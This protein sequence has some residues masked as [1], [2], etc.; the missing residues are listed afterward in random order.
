MSNSPPRPPSHRPASL[1][2]LPARDH[3]G[4]RPLGSGPFLDTPSLSNLP[5]LDGYTSIAVSQPVSPLIGPADAVSRRLVRRRNADR[6]LRGAVGPNSS[7]SGTPPPRNNNDVPNPAP[8]P[9]LAPVPAP[10]PAA[11]P[12]VQWVGSPPAPNRI[13]PD[14]A[15]AADERALLRLKQSLTDRFLCYHISIDNLLY[16]DRDQRRPFWTRMPIPLHQG[17][18]PGHPHVPPGEELDM[19]FT[20]QQALDEDEDSRQRVTQSVRGLLHRLRR[21]HRNRSRPRNDDVRRSAAD[22]LTTKL[23]SK[24]Q[25]AGIQFKRRLGQGGFGAVFLFEMVGEKGV[26][27]PIVVKGSTRELRDG[28]EAFS[29]ELENINVSLLKST[30]LVSLILLYCILRD[31]TWANTYT[32]VPKTKTLY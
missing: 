3:S 10:A 13:A 1:A 20:Y 16:W 27:Y 24:F 8:I 30:D 11:A 21:I 17:E 31:V 29:G 4:W 14:V 28:S 12:H 6:N 7:R 5:V 25:P 15:R 26:T 2:H 18:W 32:K 22:R 19:V 9:A 23:V